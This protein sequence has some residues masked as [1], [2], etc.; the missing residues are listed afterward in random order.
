MK[1]IPFQL[2][3]TFGI[4]KDLLQQLADGE[5][6]F[7]VASQKSI[8]NKHIVYEPILTENFIVVGSP[9][10]DLSDLKKHLKDKD[11]T[12][13]EKWLINQQWY[14]YSK[15]TAFKEKLGICDSRPWF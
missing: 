3:A 10:L 15:E 8:E 9:D 2:N 1:N 5:L 14:A 4:A 13:I 6:D 7:V 12:A 11:F